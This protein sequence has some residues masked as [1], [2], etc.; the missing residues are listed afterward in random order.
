M[1]KNDKKIFKNV[2]KM[3]VNKFK[4]R[5]FSTPHPIQLGSIKTLN[6]NSGH[7]VV[8]KYITHTESV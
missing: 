7:S 4:P 3:L 5:G 6:Q 1:L 2:Q 8:C